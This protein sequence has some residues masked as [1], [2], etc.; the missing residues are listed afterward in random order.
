MDPPLVCFFFKIAKV[1]YAHVI[2]YV[3]KEYYTGLSLMIS[4]FW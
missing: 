1:K 3:K 4:L 2:T